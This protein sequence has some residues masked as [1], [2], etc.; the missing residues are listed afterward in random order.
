MKTL[1]R[2]WADDTGATIVEIAFALPVF[3]TFI[4][5][6]VQLGLV[7]R[8]NAGIQNALGE[9]ARFATLFPTPADSDITARMM[10]TVDGIGPGTFTPT[11]VSNTTQRYRD[12]T[13]TYSQPT[14]LIMFRGP[15]IVITRRKRVWVAS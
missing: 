1:S 3:L 8:A 9:G 4:W 2:L 14:D 7:F 12:L 11:L 10:A 15:T 5:A 13:V 6:V